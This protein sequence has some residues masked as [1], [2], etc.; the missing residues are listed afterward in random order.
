MRGT[1]AYLT[2]HLRDLW[3][4]SSSCEST[5]AGTGNFDSTKSSTFKSLDHDFDIT[6]GSGGAMGIIVEDVVQLA[7][8]SVSNQQFGTS[9]FSFIVVVT[10]C[11]PLSRLCNLDVS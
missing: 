2:I 6:Y 9:F 4:A 7:G 1:P 11:Q 10:T 5:C 8:F 3:V